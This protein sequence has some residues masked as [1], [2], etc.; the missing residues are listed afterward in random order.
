MS[1]T[2]IDG[3]GELTRSD[4]VDAAGWE[5]TLEDPIG[6]GRSIFVEISG[7]ARDALDRSPGSVAAITREAV[8]TEGQ[9]EVEKVLE[10]PEP[11]RR[12]SLGLDGY[13]NRVD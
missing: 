4:D 8:E 12:I 10:E 9:S 6:E 13:V 7:P 11:P 3:P 2:I 1:W 5:Y